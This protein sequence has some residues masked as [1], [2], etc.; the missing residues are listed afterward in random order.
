MPRWYSESGFDSSLAQ[1]NQWRSLFTV[2]EPDDATVVVGM[3]TLPDSANTLNHR[4]HREFEMLPLLHSDMSK[5]HSHCRNTGPQTLRSG[6][7]C[8][9]E[10]LLHCGY[11]STSVRS[12][13]NNSIHIPSQPHLSPRTGH[14]VKLFMAPIFRKHQPMIKHTRSRDCQHPA[15]SLFL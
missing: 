11:L 8:K 3:A 15:L 14:G 13:A 5:D 12:T 1:F 10:D 6:V 7:T 4:R 9:A 2:L